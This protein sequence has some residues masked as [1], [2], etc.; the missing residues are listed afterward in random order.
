MKNQREIIAAA[1]GAAVMGIIWGITALVSTDPA[2]PATPPQEPQTQA[3]A[4]PAAPAET[5]GADAL[6]K[7]VSAYS[8][9]TNGN[10]PGLKLYD[11]DFLVPLNRLAFTRHVMVDDPDENY[12]SGNAPMV[13]FLFR[14]FDKG[15]KCHYFL[16]SGPL[17]RS[18]SSVVYLGENID[19]LEVK[20]AGNG[21]WLATYKDKNGKSG[22]AFVPI[23]YICGS[24]PVDDMGVAVRI[25]MDPL[26]K[27]CDQEDP[28]YHEMNAGKLFLTLQKAIREDDRETIA[29]MIRFPADTHLDRIYTRKQFLENFDRFFP[30]ATREKILQGKPED[31]MYSWRGALLPGFVFLPQCP[32]ETDAAYYIEF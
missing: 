14:I 13:A 21:Y 1:A 22:S 3:A 12:G 23:S 25:G 24:D 9:E 16:A 30:P 29:K 11:T 18:I 28:I 32:S 26:L 5:A 4:A 15:E 7:P 8:S 6:R 10:F 20:V 27:L 19:D 17:R 31:I 2:A